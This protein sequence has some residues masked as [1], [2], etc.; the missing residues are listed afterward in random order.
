MITKKEIQQHKARFVNEMLNNGYELG[1][2][3]LNCL[4]Q[5]RHNEYDANE[6]QLFICPNCGETEHFIEWLIPIK[7]KFKIFEK[8]RFELFNIETGLIDECRN[9]VLEGVAYPL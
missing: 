9:D 8:D 1:V 6:S 4:I 7:R 5:C 2:I 3:C